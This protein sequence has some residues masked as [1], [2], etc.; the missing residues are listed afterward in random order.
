[1]STQPEIAVSGLGLFSARPARV[2]VRQ[3]SGASGIRFFHSSTS[4]VVPALISHLQPA[5]GPLGGR[6]TV[7]G[8]DVFSVATVEHLLSALAGMGL[9]HADI[10]IDADEL[11]ILDGSAAEFV[12]MLHGSAFRAPAAQEIRLTQTVR[13]DD[14]SSGAWIE[15]RP[16]IRLR[17]RYELRYPAGAGI[18]EQHYEWD[19]DPLRYASEIAPARTF[20]LEREALAMKAAGLFPHLTPRDM[21]VIAPDGRAIENSFRFP[22]EP[23]RHKLLDLIGDLALLGGPL[24]AEVTAHKSSHALTHELCRRIAALQP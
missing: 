14:A 5:R 22:D 20:S 3:S 7:I 15:A 21:L 10:V 23:A 17:Y 1:M 8:D 12:K 11:P 9:W 6:N 19:G 18:P 2:E 24:I 16:S 13:V 4:H